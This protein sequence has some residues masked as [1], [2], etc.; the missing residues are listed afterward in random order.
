VKEKAARPNKQGNE[1][2]TFLGPRTRTEKV[3]KD[4]VG[5]TKSRGRWIDMGGRLETRWNQLKLIGE[6]KKYIEI[7]V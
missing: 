7:L 3:R 6:D 4:H 5:G 1:N 2:A